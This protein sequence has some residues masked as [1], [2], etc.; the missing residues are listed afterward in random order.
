MTKENSDKE[1]ILDIVEAKRIGRIRQSQ[2]LLE[3][4][5]QKLSS[6]LTY[7]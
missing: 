1:K 3:W 7:Y 5:K 2:T 6:Q 4:E